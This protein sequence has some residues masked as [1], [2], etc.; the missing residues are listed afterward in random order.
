MQFAWGRRSWLAISGANLITS[1]IFMLFH[2]AHHPPL[3]AL[4]ILAPSLL[5]GYFRE[6]HESVYPPFALHSVYNLGYLLA[7]ARQRI[8][9][10]HIICLVTSF[11]ATFLYIES[12]LSVLISNSL[13]LPQGIILN[14]K[15]ATTTNTICPTMVRQGYSKKNIGSSP[16]RNKSSGDWLA[17]Q[18]DKRGL[19]HDLSASL[20]IAQW[21]YGQVEHAGST[22][23]FEHNQL[24]PL[25]HSWQ[26]LFI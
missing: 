9:R 1:V 19:V 6:R 26:S 18:F 15:V 17:E 22:V 25:E 4:S 21:T 2:F 10:S 24:V 20:Q 23:W 11:Q 13:H 8:L 7:I 3:W 14:N 12:V 16:N 5:F